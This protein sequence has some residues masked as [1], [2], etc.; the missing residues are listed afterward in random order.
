M[1][2]SFGKQF[3]FDLLPVLLEPLPAAAGS[4]RIRPGK[5]RLTLRLK[6]TGRRKFV[7]RRWM[8]FR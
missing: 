1:N 6:M 8:G 7:L 5:P 4:R 2:T 3:L